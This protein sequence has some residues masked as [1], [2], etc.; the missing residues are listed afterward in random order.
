MH[1]LRHT[2]AVTAV[3]VVAACT[4][5]ADPVDFD[6]QA[7]TTASLPA[8][9]TNAHADDPAAAALGRELFFDKGFSS[10]GTVACVSCHDPANGFS[11]PK[12]FSVGVRGQLGTR[13]AMP[14]TAAAFHPFLLWDGKADAPWL[15]PLKAVENPREMDFPRAEVVKRLESTYRAKYEVIFGPLPTS[16]SSTEIARAFTNFGKAIEAYER[17]LLCTD[18]RFDRWLRGEE[19]LTDSERAG[20]A[21]FQDR[22]CNRCHSGPSFSDGKFHDIGI[23]ST[24]QGRVLGAPA[25]LA[26]PFNGAGAFSDDPAAGAAK[27]ETVKAET[28]QVGAFRTASLRGVGQRTFFGHASHKRTIREF[29]QDI[30]RGRGGGGRNGRGGDNATVGTRDPLL[31]DVNVDDDEMD[32]LI[33]F[34]HTLDCPAPPADLLAPAQ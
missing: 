25:L 23:P 15:Q 5:H 26:D 27:L 21:V 28:A 13:H 24:D 30:Y 31:D 7:L 12:P 4:D 29:V 20:G 6:T 17:K 16:S 14:V 32:D 34:L 18:T 33:A 2:A 19:Q 9:P 10:D 8:S 3:V 11:D 1:L 22:H